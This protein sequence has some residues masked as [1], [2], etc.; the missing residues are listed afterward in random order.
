[1]NVSLTE[2]HREW[3]KEGLAAEAHASSADR[4]QHSNSSD[5]TSHVEKNV[6]KK[7]AAGYHNK[8]LTTRR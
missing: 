7:L 2:R 3:T 5:G 4:Q 6:R 8:L 1:M